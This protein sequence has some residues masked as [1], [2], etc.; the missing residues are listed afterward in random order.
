VRRGTLRFRVGEERFDAPAGS[1]MFIP[2]GRPH[3]FQN[4]GDEPAALFV[5]FTPAGMEAF[6]EGSAAL[7]PGPPDPAA[8]GAIAQRAGMEILGPPV[9]AGGPL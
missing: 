3:I 8:W 2:R 9:R 5:I 4:V 6:F 7:P 1:L